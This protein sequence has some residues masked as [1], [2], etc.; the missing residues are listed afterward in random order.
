MRNFKKGVSLM[1]ASIMILGSFTPILAT[2]NETQ[3]T[4][5]S[6]TLATDVYFNQ[7]SSFTVTIPKFV[8]L[9]SSKTSAYE[10]TVLGNISS[11][12]K[13]TVIP[14][15][16]F[17]MTDQASKGTPKNP[18]V[19]SI[20]QDKTEWLWNE[21][22][23]G[24]NIIGK[25]NIDASMLS[26]GNWEGSFW[27]NITYKNINLLSVEKEEY[28]VIGTNSFNV[29]ATNPSNGI[30]TA[31]SS[32]KNVATA[33]VKNNTLTINPINVGTT[34]ITV[35]SAETNNYYS[36]TT[37]FD[38]TITKLDNE[39]SVPQDS[40]SVVGTNP[41]TI[42]ASNPS[43]GTL[44]A[45]SS[46][47]NIATVSV[48][49]NVLTIEPATTG[50]VTITLTSAETNN[51]HSATTA[52]NVTITKLDNT[53]TVPNTTY[54]IIGDSP[55]NVT[56][57][58]KGGALTA[59]SSSTSTA[60]VAVNN[61]NLTITPKKTGTVTIT[62][63]SAST[64]IYHSATTTFKVTITKGTNNLTVPS[65][66]YMIT[67]GAALSVTAS[68]PKGGSLTATSSDTS[69]AT[70]SVSG[71]KLTIT[72]KAEGVVTI[73][74]TSAATNLYN[75]ATTTFKA[76][77]SHY[78][79]DGICQ[80]CDEKDVSQLPAGLYDAN[81]NLKTSWATLINNKIVYNNNGVIT[82]NPVIY[83]NG[84]PPTN[85]SSS[86]LSGIL[87]LPEGV[88]SLAVNSFAA[89]DNLTGIVL[90][91]TL[92][93]IGTN[94]FY[95]LYSKLNNI[96][97]DPD[98]EYFKTVNGILYNI[99]MTTI[100]KYPANKTATTFTIPNSV[101]IIG[102]SAFI[103]NN[104]LKNVTIPYGV[105]II[106]GSAFDWCQSLTTVSLPNSVTRIGA[107]AFS[108]CTNLTSITLSDNLTFI[109][110]G[111]FAENYKI[112][113]IYIP[114]SCITIA[115]DKIDS[116]YR[117]CFIYNNS[118]IKIYCG[119]TSK[120]SGWSD[121]WNC[122]KLTTNS[123]SYKLTTYWGYTRAQFDALN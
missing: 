32:N 74:V 17:E 75:A 65:S 57:T 50:T 123:S 120:P 77:I 37:E 104:Y 105:R 41:F 115:E 84:N 4:S 1:L 114:A 16:S 101:E 54:S 102:S 2:V 80:R 60:T 78:Y 53:L 100:I 89:C 63:N 66:S 35:N 10:V 33:D 118:N 111:A 38:V 122:Y 81:W 9:D 39:L 25:G 20:T 71:N 51:Y 3:T 18:V 6:E 49:G 29:T 112:S 23:E 59:T 91:S 72:P 45:I 27:F 119:A 8:T 85:N 56:A 86:I 73:T 67:N 96:I 90:P 98:N 99:D 26:A 58:N 69:M 92:Q 97:V 116:G 21:I 87:I 68:N 107:W 31:T 15:E 61:N 46:D 62:V 95:S 79:I 30:L 11:A 42:E 44:T 14:E 106:Q 12:G 76:N 52:F 13:I 28:S 110:Q 103:S 34:T 121:Y 48:S 108:K 43:E 36:A 82:T 88:T 109:G 83:T 24:S 40:Y 7:D 70:V 55:L 64:D 117:S 94:S 113:K 47:E 5:T 22:L 19:A 93:T